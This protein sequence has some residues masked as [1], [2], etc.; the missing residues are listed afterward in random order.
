[1]KLPAGDRAIVDIAKLRD[2]CL[3]P[4]HPRGKHKARIFAAALGLSMNDAHVLRE[5]LLDAA[6]T[7]DVVPGSVDAFGHRYW[8]ETGIVH[9]SNRAVLKSA[10]MIRTGENVPRLITCYVKLD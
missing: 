8:M 5:H 1:M 4:S 7:A 10:W 3:S 2:Y 6:M 9:G